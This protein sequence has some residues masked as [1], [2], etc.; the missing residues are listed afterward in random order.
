LATAVQ[1]EGRPS[2]HREPMGASSIMMSIAGA[3]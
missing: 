2:A 3:D 1:G